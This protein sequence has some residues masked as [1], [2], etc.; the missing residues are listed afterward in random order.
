MFREAFDCLGLSWG[1]SAVAFVLDL[2]RS[3]QTQSAE[4]GL[5]LLECG[6]HRPIAGA[7]A[8]TLSRGR[9]KMTWLTFGG[10]NPVRMRSMTCEGWKFV[11]SPVFFCTSWMC[12][13]WCMTPWSWRSSRSTRWVRGVP[14]VGGFCAL[15]QTHVRSF[16]NGRRR[17]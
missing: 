5:F 13:T 10:F 7:T 2:A 4:G 11:G 6:D 16:P 3:C 8:S 12:R 9:L 14:C 15:L 17:S 1:D